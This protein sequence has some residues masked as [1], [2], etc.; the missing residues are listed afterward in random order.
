MGKLIIFG[1][2]SEGRELAG[3]AVSIG[4]P[5]LL[6]VVSDYGKRTAGEADGL[7]VRCGVLDKEGM[8]ELLRQELPPLVLDATHPHAVQATEQIQAACREAQIRCL[9]V[10]REIGAGTAGANGADGE[11][12][13]VHTPQEAREILAAD[14]S[15]V[16][17]A[18]GSKE[19]PVFLEAP[20]LKGRIYARVLPDSKVLAECERQGLKGRQVIAMQGPFSEEMNCAMIRAV[21][22]GWLVT[23]E[24]G[25]R[26]GFGEKLRAANKCGIRTVVI[27]RPGQEA[28]VSVGQ[29]RAEV[30]RLGGRRELVL[31]GMGMGSGNQ[32]TLEA[33]ESLRQCDVVLGAPR[34]LEDVGKWVEGKPRVALYLA[35][36]VENWLEGHPGY[37]RVAVVY[38]GDTGFYSGCAS[39]LGRLK[40]QGR[41]G[42]ENFRIRVFAG[43]S[44]LSCL[45]SRLGCPWEEIYPASI[46]GRECDVEQLLREHPKVF[47]LL[48]GE[49]NLGKLCRRLVRAGMGSVQVSAGIRLGYDDER[50]IKGS[51]N[52]LC[53]RKEDSLAAVILERQAG[54]EDIG[55]QAFYPRENPD[56]QK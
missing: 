13:F 31:V 30:A 27:Q 41:P 42:R 7:S 44:T 54:G 48:G 35:E 21:G 19:L 39:L 24:S 15:P 18:T 4:I 50:I 9:R 6:S 36:D 26:G 52:K 51:A 14:G 25:S 55:R 8:L 33:L 53:G 43:I 17:L 45:C 12:F 37:G 5:T 38:S 28:G 32:L 16:L 40:N 10:L 46:H 1:G 11:I 56:D 23:K 20:H 47:L 34:M 2:T 3:Y 29:A 22:A 49:E